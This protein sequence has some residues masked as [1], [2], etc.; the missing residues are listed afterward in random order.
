MAKSATIA[1]MDEDSWIIRR[2]SA[3]DKGL[4]T[5]VGGGG[6]PGCFVGMLMT[7]R[8]SSVGGSF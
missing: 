6:L 1:W 8:D 5:G 7:A 4:V 3:V 2:L